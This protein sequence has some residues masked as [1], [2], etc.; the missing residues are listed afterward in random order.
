MNDIDLLFI[1]DE[2]PAAEAMLERLGYAGKR[3]S[4]ELG[5]GVTKHVSSFRRSNDQAATPNPYLSTETD[6]TVEPHTSLE[7]SWFGLKVD[8]TPGVRD[9][10]V[11]ANLGGQPCRVLANEDLLLHVCVHF[12]FHLIM[13]APSMVQLTDLLAVTTRARVEWQIL[14]RRAI[15]RRAAP[16]L[17]RDTGG[18]LQAYQPTRL[19]RHFAAHAAE[20]TDQ[21]SAAYPAR[22]ARSS[23]DGALGARHTKPLGCV[24]NCVESGQHRY[25][26]NVTRQVMRRDTQPS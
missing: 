24:E 20:A 22:S 1:P 13:G 19:T 17:S 16:A 23:R 25:G 14:V 26:K 12:C 5:A 7:E 9:R 15:E 18:A 4:A 11:T 3:K 8:I 6:R 21:Y 2:L 10:A